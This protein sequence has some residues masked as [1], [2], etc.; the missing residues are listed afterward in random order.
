MR[1][2]SQEQLSTCETGLGLDFTHYPQR[3]YCCEFSTSSRIVLDCE[4]RSWPGARSRPS[5]APD[6]LADLAMAGQSGCRSAS[7]ESVPSAP[8]SSRPLFKIAG[9]G[10]RPWSGLQGARPLAWPR[11]HRARRAVAHVST[12]IPTPSTRAYPPLVRITSG[13]QPEASCRRGAGS[14]LAGVK[15]HADAACDARD[16][17]EPSNPVH[18]VRGAGSW[19]ELP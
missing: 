13:R 4:V 3:R 7:P 9:P 6:S 10:T 18:T 16:A 11:G 1:G 5:A 14:D 8:S 19:G 2:F 15:H 17:S 12:L